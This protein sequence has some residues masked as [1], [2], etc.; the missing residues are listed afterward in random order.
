MRFKLGILLATLAAC[1]GDS[2]TNNVGDAA[3]GVPVADGGEEDPNDIRRIG[4]TGKDGG[5][6]KDGGPVVPKDGGVGTGG[7]GAGGMVGMGG[8]G[9][10]LGGGGTGG[11][12][13]GL[14]GDGTCASPYVIPMNTPHTSVTVDTSTRQHTLDLAC[15]GT[16]KDIVLSFVLS[17]K[18]MVYAD[19]FGAKW[20]TVL[21]FADACNA[22]SVQN[23]TEGMTSC[24]NDAC[25]STQSQAI[26]MLGFGKHYLV[27]SGANAE[28]GPVTIH[29]QHALVGSGTF[30]LLPAG[31]GAV[32]GKTTGAGL[33][34]TC[35]A[36]GAENTY[37]WSSCPDYAGG[38]FSATTCNG[39]AFDTLLMLQIPKNDAQTCADD[40]ANC[41]VLST[42]GA[43]VA[44]GAGIHVLLLDG[45]TIKS[46]GDY[47]IT[48]T[49]P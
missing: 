26:S 43:T 36:T 23:A 9:G 30:S 48:Y 28:S 5:V 27:I 17:Q 19:T 44:P 4:G 42:V 47:K 2:G 8:M 40:D 24:S 6:G 14:V 41:G 45:D 49:R 11:S 31:A 18:E 38:A 22:T 35:E 13:P 3:V 20:N 32:Q 7:M 46:S 25:G 15:G 10:M 1:G 16:G 33:V 34:S 37:W 21:S 39:A 29:F 12:V